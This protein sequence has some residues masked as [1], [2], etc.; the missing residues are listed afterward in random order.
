MVFA[1]EIHEE[2]KYLELFLAKNLPQSLCH[3]GFDIK[4]TYVEKII[5]VATADEYGIKCSDKSTE[6]N[7]TMNF[8]VPKNFTKNDFDDNCMVVGEKLNYFQ[9]YES[10]IKV[11]HYYYEVIYIFVSA[12]LVEKIPSTKEKLFGFGK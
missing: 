1:H 11:T 9:I 2:A 3:P 6:A 12:K 10:K 8:P 7:V 4:A 5:P